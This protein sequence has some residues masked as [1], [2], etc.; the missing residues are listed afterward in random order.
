MNVE[1][2]IEAAQFLFWEYLFL[3][4][5]IVS[6]QCESEMSD[7]KTKPRQQ[8]TEEKPDNSSKEKHWQDS[9]LQS[10]DAKSGPMKPKARGLAQGATLLAAWRKM[11]QQ[12]VFLY[13]MSGPCRLP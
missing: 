4:F 13:A 8:S 9:N 10:P 12:G 5:G 2:G 7:V 3:I 11:A 6:L 1:T